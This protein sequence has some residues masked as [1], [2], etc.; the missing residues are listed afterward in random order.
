MKKTL[1]YLIFFCLVI[2][3]LPGCA[4]RQDFGKRLDSI[5]SYIDERPDSA[6]AA[7]DTLRSEKIRG[8]KD[9]AKFSLLYSMALDK[10]D[11][12][13][14][15]DS[16]IAPAVDWYSRHGSPDERLKAYY[17]Q[18]RIYENAGDF[19]S[20]MESFLKAEKYAGQVKD[21]SAA[22]RLFFAK[23]RIYFSLFDIENALSNMKE[24]GKYS[25]KGQN[26]NNYALSL[27]NI[28]NCHIVLS[29]LDSTKVYLDRIRPLLPDIDEN[30]QSLYHSLV[31]DLKLNTYPDSTFYYIG[32]Y[33]SNVKNPDLIDHL[34]V[35]DAYLVSGHPDSA[36]NAAHQY[37]QS[38][39]DCD[40]DIRYQITLSDIYDSLGMDTESKEAYRRYVDLSDSVDMVIF[41]DS[42]RYVEEKYS[43]E[44]RLLKMRNQ[45]NL[46]WLG[47]IS[48]LSAS[49]A[50]IQWLYSVLKKRNT[51]KKQ[52]EQ[53]RKRLEA[54]I[55]DISKE[56]DMLTKTLR[57]G[58]H[59]DDIA[60][61]AIRKRLAVL[62]D[63]FAS[64]IAAGNARDVK[65]VAENLEQLMS[66]RE[67][68]V[69]ST[70]MSYSIRYPEFVKYLQSHGL[71][72]WETG[73]CCLYTMGLKGKEIG[74]FIRRSG[75]NNINSSIRR[76]LG[77]E[78]YSSRLDRFLMDK[79][80]ELSR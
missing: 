64:R 34:A 38:G 46:L 3:L 7:L 47:L 67:D 45:K 21:C 50:V 26:I 73:Y 29:N 79:F 20:A 30:K 8:R 25:L 14:T 74:A 40:N 24:S 18:G 23:G 75:Y 39:I 1:S 55:S 62:D 42:T 32:Q 66:D 37:A 44:I 71:T 31:L 33:L 52:L 27:L 68:F 48:I 54:L 80:K 61:D 12:E 63:F 60:S 11:C 9:K 56:R 35:A 17:Y 15:T 78:K 76:K 28:A 65:N 6:L 2:T 70:G 69:Y 53:E 10:T 59:P 4:I 51:E 77:I 57:N 72:T 13:L 43:D 22:G 19:E 41:E 49:V 36:L 58:D 5:E 16:I